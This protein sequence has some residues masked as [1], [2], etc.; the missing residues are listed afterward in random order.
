VLEHTGLWGDGDEIEAIELVEKR[1]NVKLRNED[2]AGIWTVGD[3]WRTLLNSN[4]QL[5]DDRRS[6]LRFV[7]ALTWYTDVN[8][9]KVGK[10]TLLIEPGNQNI[11]KHLWALITRK[12]SNV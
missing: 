10:Q 9:R 3:L 11:F 2:A 5:N 4:P 1:L 7:V 6:W 12:K 8:P